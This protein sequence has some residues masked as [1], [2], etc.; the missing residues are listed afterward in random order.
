VS[1]SDPA[2][3]ARVPGA[4]S[5]D[6]G[7]GTVARSSAGAGNR[8]VGAH[9]PPES[10]T[11]RPRS[12]AGEGRT[13]PD[14]GPAHIGGLD[15]L[16][17]VAVA[18]VVA[19]H[20][21]PDRWTGGFLGVD[22]FFVISGFLITQ[23][24]L[25]ELERTGRIR[26]GAFYRRRATRLFPAELVLIAAVA[27]AG[28]VVWT[29]ERPTLGPSLLASLG[30][31]SN[32]WLIYAHQSY[33]VATGRPP[34]LQH[35]W[36]LAIEEQYYL[37]WPALIILVTAWARSVRPRIRPAHVVAVVAILLALVS[38][39]LMV[40]HAIRSG[41]P[42][43]ADSARVYFGTDTHATGL[44]LGSAAGALRLSHD[45]SRPDRPTV[46]GSNW[47]IVALAGLA[48]LI[49]EFADVDEFQ[50]ALFR[51]GLTAFDGL[52]LVVVIAVSARG[53]LVGRALDTRV[54][55]WVG[56]RSYAIYLW[57][58]PV[59]VTTRPGVD[60]HGPVALIDFLRIGLIVI[61]ADLSY[62]F[63]EQRFRTRRADVRVETSG[64]RFGTP[65]RNLSIAGP[66]VVLLLVLINSVS[67]PSP[68]SRSAYPSAKP[69][70]A[71]VAV[72][73]PGLSAF[74]D[75][76]L[77]GAAPALRRWDPRASFD[78]VEGA[79]PTT[80][81]DDIARASGRHQLHRV[82]LI[83]IGNNGIIDPDQLSA[84]LQ[85]LPDRARV[86]ILTD[87]VPRDWEAV[88]NRTIERVAARF[89]NAAVIDWHR[90]AGQH[91]DWLYGD[92]IHLD[93]AG[94]AGYARLVE[95]AAGR[96]TRGR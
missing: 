77:L 76:V 89:P 91:P 49:E 44:L 53:S 55:R 79:Q 54:P 11:V 15:G 73:T 6:G 67:A 72:S 71:P 90:I 81:L 70:I 88:N 33:F 52:A 13:P 34:M 40:W 51:G 17:A 1:R 5:V 82:V 46:W 2:A 28:L 23:L 93:P 29:D 10:L 14:R 9:V 87:R 68:V 78:A 27:G 43:R 12:R 56:Q 92:G 86:V 35:L 80:I 31:V 50:P 95:V 62:R 24:L 22:V 63:V 75:S 18:A 42:Y 60:V 16:R 32:W 58:W 39:S 36:S 96:V 8:F 26:I 20:L 83:H 41:I 61:L 94:A 25:H 7:L 69:R 45:R 65:A 30:N 21:D 48:I 38:S 37:V 64:S 4:G 85:T 3:Q 47:D 19:F 84:V 66:A 57:H 59:C 74:G